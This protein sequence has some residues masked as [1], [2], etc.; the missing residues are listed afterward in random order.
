MTEK[1][2]PIHDLVRDHSA[3]ERFTALSWQGNFQ[4]YLAVVE[5]NPRVVA[6][7]PVPDA[8]DFQVLKTIGINEFQESHDVAPAEF[9]LPQGGRVDK[10]G[11]LADGGVFF[12]RSRINLGALPVPRVHHCRPIPQVPVVHGGAAGKRKMQSAAGEQPER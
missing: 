6:D 8:P 5:K 9:D 11:A 7:H 2:S 3:P 1:K 4:E 10:A 12:F